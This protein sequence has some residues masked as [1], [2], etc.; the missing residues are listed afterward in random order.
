[1]S[2]LI[3]NTYNFISFL[4]Q[5]LDNTRR[6]TTALMHASHHIAQETRR[7][8]LYADN[9]HQHP[10]HKQGMAILNIAVFVAQ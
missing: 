1:M 3:I 7:K 10:E 2:P 4:T 5:P 8:K 6:A 9:H